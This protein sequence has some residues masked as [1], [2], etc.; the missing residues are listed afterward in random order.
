[1]IW[2]HIKLYVVDKCKQQ[3]DCKCIEQAAWQ[4][5][6][7]EVV[8]WISAGDFK[9]AFVDDENDINYWDFFLPMDLCNSEGS[10]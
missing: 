2:A 7:N 6:V 3:L 9:H 5:R 4:V 10:E 1:M 8:F